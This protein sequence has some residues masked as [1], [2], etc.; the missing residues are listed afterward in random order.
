M[1]AIEVSE[2]AGSDVLEAFECDAPEPTDGEVRLAVEDAGVNF[3]D[4]MQRHGHYQGGPQAPYVPGME[5]AGTIDA[6]GEG[7]GTENPANGWSP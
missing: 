6:V 1:R 7:V 5:V 3:A 4:I 2:F